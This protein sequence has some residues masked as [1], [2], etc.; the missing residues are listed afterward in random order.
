[1]D[2]HL[3]IY[4]LSEKI[5]IQGPRAHQIEAP[6][7]S[8]ILKNI[9]KKLGLNCHCTHQNGFVCRTSKLLKQQPL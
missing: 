4:F 8:R 6:E 1:M 7:S 2:F 5:I 9:V 3:P